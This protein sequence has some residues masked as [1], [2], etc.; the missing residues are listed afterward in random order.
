MP[1]KLRKSRK[2]RGSRTCGYG[3]VGQHRC[4]GGK[5]QR[6]IGRHKHQWSFVIRYEPEYFGK[7][8]FTSPNFRNEVN[9]I[10]VGRLD[11]AAEKLSTE[12]E[13]GKL[14]VDLQ[15]LGYTKLLGSGKVTKPLSVKIPS[16][17]KTA[18]RKIKS[19]GGEILSEASKKKK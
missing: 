10:N 19:A 6:K 5:P 1:H 15:N 16:Y 7:K 17:S 13:K 14:L 2:T 8:G 3:R 12:K 18:Y 9:V 4:S 11:E